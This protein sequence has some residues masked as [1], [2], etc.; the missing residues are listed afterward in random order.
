MS[1]H[2]HIP[3]LSIGSRRR[4]VVALVV[5][6]LALLSLAAS[7]VH[8]QEV[9]VWSPGGAGH[10]EVDTNGAGGRLLEVDE[11]GSESYRIR[12]S[13][14]PTA[15][16]WWIILRVDGGTRADGDY[17]GISWVPSVGWE[18]DED[19]WDQWRTITIRGGE[20]QSTTETR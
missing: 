7:R 4:L 20:R 17:N 2:L 3:F 6:L 9:D 11:E 18:F 15:D 16:G 10:V 12:L 8:A 1:S 19:N 13:H 14:P 5:T